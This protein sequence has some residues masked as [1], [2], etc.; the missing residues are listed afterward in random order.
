MSKTSTPTPNTTDLAVELHCKLLSRGSDPLVSVEQ[1]RTW[2]A[3]DRAAEQ[4]P[5]TPAEQPPGGDD[6]PPPALADLAAAA[7]DVAVLLNGNHEDA[8]TIRRV[9][10]RLAEGG[11]PLPRRFR[12]NST[13]DY[14]AEALQVLARALNDARRPA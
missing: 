9:R 12:G 7:H 6:Q 2:I 8:V 1:L 3:E 10:T 4:A 11:L 5:G 14:P 13:D